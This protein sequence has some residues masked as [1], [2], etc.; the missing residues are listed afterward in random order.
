MHHPEGF[1]KLFCHE[2]WPEIVQIHSSVAA[3]PLLRV[4]VPSSSKGVGFGSEFSRA[5]L[6]YQVECGK[7]FQPLGLSSG[8][9]P[10]GSEI[11]EILVVH[12]YLYQ[13]CRSLKVMSPD[14][15]SFEYCK[16]FLV[17]CVVVQFCSV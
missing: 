13:D 7:E 8:Q 10:G 11:F 9:D 1:G 4:D 5:E 12:K 2:D 6:D 15:K 17:M 14:H 3:F 16:E